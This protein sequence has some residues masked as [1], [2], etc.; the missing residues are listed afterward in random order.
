MLEPIK[1]SVVFAFE[2]TV[3]NGRFVETS[4]SGIYLGR[5]EAG[6]RDA[7]A[8]R[9]VKVLAVGPDVPREI[10]AGSRVLVEPSQWTYG[11]EYDG[12]K[13]WRTTADKIM[14]TG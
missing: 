7:Q 3:V 4:D 11:M 10:V 5:S 9:W 2:D 14:C 1:D 12:V 8:P 13:L 6:Q